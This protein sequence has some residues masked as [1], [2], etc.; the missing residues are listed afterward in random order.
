LAINLSV[1][2]D[3]RRAVEVLNQGVDH[4]VWD[5]L[6]VSIRGRLVPVHREDADFNVFALL[7]LL[8]RPDAT[9]AIVDA[10]KILTARRRGRE[11]RR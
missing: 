11:V 8:S 4:D 5:E 9:Q 2:G 6:L 7:T 10:R 1:P 3:L